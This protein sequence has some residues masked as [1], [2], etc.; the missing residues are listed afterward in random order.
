MGLCFCCFGHSVL[1]DSFA[2]PW[3]VTHQAPL[4][5]R[6]SGQEYWSAIRNLFPPPGDLPDPRIEPTSPQLLHCRQILYCWTAREGTREAFFKMSKFKYMCR[7][8]AE[9]REKWVK[10]KA[11]GKVWASK[12]KLEHIMES[13]KC[14]GKEF[15]LYSI[16]RREPLKV[17]KEGNDIGFEKVT[18]I[19]I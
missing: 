12:D 3:T 16:G 17:Y 8:E 2:T 11:H 1:S 18:L 7:I 9:E 19:V 6:F 14:C 15:W 13:F 4:S 10:N 5:M